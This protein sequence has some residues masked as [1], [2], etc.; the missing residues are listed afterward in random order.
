MTCLSSQQEVYIA[1]VTAEI[2]VAVAGRQFTLDG[3]VVCLSRYKSNWQPRAHDIREVYYTSLRLSAPA[4]RKYSSAS[5]SAAPVS[6]YLLSR[7][8]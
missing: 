8:E 3:I 1:A 5:Q 4:K 7:S 2:L 6:V